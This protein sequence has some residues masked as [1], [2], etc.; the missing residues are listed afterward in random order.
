[1]EG[2]RW[3]PALLLAGALC[4]LPT[5][6]ALHWAG[7]DR[8]GDTVSPVVQGAAD[9]CHDAKPEQLG[10]LLSPLPLS[11]NDASS[12]RDAGDCAEQSTPVVPDGEY[13]GEIGPMDPEDWYTAEVGADGNATRGEFGDRFLVQINI[14]LHYDDSTSEELRYAEAWTPEAWTARDE[15]AQPVDN[16]T[17]LDD[18]GNL[19]LRWHVSEDPT[20]GDA[21]EPG[22]YL[23]RLTFKENTDCADPSPSLYPDADYSFY[24]GCRPH[25]LVVD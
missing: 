18:N 8:V 14:T 4:L 2:K 5:A 10:G 3:I 17:T 7:V 21:H 1:M 9:E 23:I 15:G 16:N 11:Q 12:C 22:V 20:H 6:G 19:T 25:C 13:T 24:L